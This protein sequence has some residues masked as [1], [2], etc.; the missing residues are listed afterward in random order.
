MKELH[1]EFV[2]LVK[3]TDEEVKKAQSKSSTLNT[4]SGH[5][6]PK[7]E[8]LVTK[9]LTLEDLNSGMSDIVV[10]LLQ[11]KKDIEVAQYA[12]QVQ[13][14]FRLGQQ[15]VAQATASK[16]EEI[17]KAEDEKQR[18]EELKEKISA[19][20]VDPEA[21]RRPGQRPE[22]LRNIRNAQKLIEESKSSE[23]ASNEK[24]KKS[25][26]KFKKKSNT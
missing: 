8:A 6:V 20:E 3:T 14:A 7:I 19:G 17:L 24:P 16:T 15:L 11:I 23:E 13:V 9:V 18:T 1:E 21:H 10:S 22:S 4:L 2:E 26:G 5:I 25:S 12:E